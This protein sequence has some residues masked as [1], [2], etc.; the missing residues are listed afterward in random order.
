ML[1]F[2]RGL[3]FK[4]ILIPIGGLGNRLRVISSAMNMGFK[5]ITLIN[6]KSKTMNCEV[7]DFLNL[8]K[9][10]IVR[11]I[12]ISIR[13]DIFVRRMFAIVVNIVAFFSIKNIACS[14]N[15]RDVMRKHKL[16]VTCHEFLS[17]FISP[18]DLIKVDQDHH[19]SFCKNLNQI[20]P[21]NYSAIHIRYGD[22]DRAKA[23]FSMRECEKFIESSLEPVYLATDSQKLKD[24]FIEKYTSKIITSIKTVSRDSTLGIKDAISEIYILKEAVIFKP[25]LQSSFSKTVLSLRKKG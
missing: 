1:N 15:S 5:K 18:G 22:N 3:K 24:Y 9:T 11:V 6:I 16:V 19:N 14:Y 10:N 25:S 23:L 2:T 8:E 21:K 13:S 20:L 7:D 12:N 4:M 17:G